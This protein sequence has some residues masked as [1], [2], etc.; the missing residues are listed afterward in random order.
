MIKIFNLIIINIIVILATIIKTIIIIKII[1]KEIK[2]I[3][4]FISIFGSN[5]KQATDNFKIV[6]VVVEEE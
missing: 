4:Y 6:V 2:L 5:I 1:F 3:S